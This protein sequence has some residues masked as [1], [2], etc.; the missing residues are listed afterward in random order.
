MLKNIY[1]SAALVFLPLTTFTQGTDRTSQI[2]ATL[3][4]IAQA[5][6][7]IMFEAQTAGTLSRRA[8]GHFEEVLQDNYKSATKACLRAFKT[9]FASS[10]YATTLEKVTDEQVK[11]II[12]YLVKY[13][14]IVI[15][16]SKY[17]LEQKVQKVVSAAKFSNQEEQLFNVY[18]VVYTIT[19]GAQMLIKKLELQEK[20]L[21][22]ELEALQS[23]IQANQ[24]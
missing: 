7:D 5:K 13:N 15:D 14:D 11:F 4:H 20:K 19:L 2:N 8:E 24:A 9:I 12:E 22:A 16:P 23:T 21:I 17:P 18:Y 6:K 1:L 10:E 3:A